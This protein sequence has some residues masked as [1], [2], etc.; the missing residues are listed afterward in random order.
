M[1]NKSSKFSSNK[2]IPFENYK[3][4]LND[5]DLNKLSVFKRELKSQ[6]NVEKALYI[7]VSVPNPDKIDLDNAALYNTRVNCFGNRE[8]VL[9]ERQKSCNSKCE[10]S[11]SLSDNVCFDCPHGNCVID[12]EFDYPTKITPAF[13]FTEVKKSHKAS[14][15]HPGQYFLKITVN[16]KTARGFSEISF[17]KPLID[18]LMTFVD[19]PSLD[20]SCIKRFNPHDERIN[21]IMII[22]TVQDLKEKQIRIQLFTLP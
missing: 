19:S 11:Y 1:N 10:Y 21:K 4:F 15:I 13:I 14:K 22:R 17:L 16:K 6:F 5:D 8:I 20:V 18:G 12:C 7:S 9:L 3:N 2:P